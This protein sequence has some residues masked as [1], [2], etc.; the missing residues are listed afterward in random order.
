[1]V[2][3]VKEIIES[4]KTKLAESASSEWEAKLSHMGSG[5]PSGVKEADEPENKDDA[6]D[7]KEVKEETPEEVASEEVTDENK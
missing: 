4:A 1:M 5:T 6:E 2:K 7:K 3:D